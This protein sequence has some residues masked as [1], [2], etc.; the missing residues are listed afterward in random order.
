[1]TEPYLIIKNIDQGGNEYHFLLNAHEIPKEGWLRVFLEEKN[2]DTQNKEISVSQELDNDLIRHVFN[3]Y[4]NVFHNDELANQTIKVSFSDLVQVRKI[5]EFFNLPENAISSFKLMC[6]FENVYYLEKIIYFFVADPIE[7][8]MSLDIR[9]ENLEFTG[10]FDF[11]FR[12]TKDKPDCV[13]IN[14]NHL[15]YLLFY[16]KVNKIF[17]FQ[18]TLDK[19]GNNKSIQKFDVSPRQRRV[20]YESDP[21]KIY[22]R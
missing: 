19:E 18:R 12:D 2:K 4:I 21:I 9:W 16:Y 20:D 7:Q 13:Q 22:Y 17:I 8:T 6:I 10:V 15:F 3:H 11:S 14:L 5:K 1:M